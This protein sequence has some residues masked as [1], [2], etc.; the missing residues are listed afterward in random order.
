MENS[1]FVRQIFIHRKWN[2]EIWQIVIMIMKIT[3]N[4][5]DVDHNNNDD[6]R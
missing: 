4:D 6:L 3:N 2:S 5:Y 1:P